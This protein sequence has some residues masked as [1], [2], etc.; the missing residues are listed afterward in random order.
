MVLKTQQLAKLFQLPV[1]TTLMGKSSYNEKDHLS[2]G[3]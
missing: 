2:L 1:T 3:S